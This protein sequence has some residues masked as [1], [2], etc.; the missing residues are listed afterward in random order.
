MN[1]RAGTASVWPVNSPVPL[2]AAT[3]AGA[4]ANEVIE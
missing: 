3:L 1:R 4:T 2:I